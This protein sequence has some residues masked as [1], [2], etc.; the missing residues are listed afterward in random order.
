V[1]QFVYTKRGQYPVIVLEG[2]E[3]ETLDVD[4]VRAW[5]SLQQAYAL[6][7]IAKALDSIGAEIG[8]A[9]AA[10]ARR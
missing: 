3:G 9:G 6:E 8:G 10:L 2:E 4:E 5:A 7:R 1:A